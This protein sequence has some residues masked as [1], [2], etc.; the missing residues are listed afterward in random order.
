MWAMVGGIF[1]AFRSSTAAR[2]FST[3]DSGR[4]LTV[5]AQAIDVEGAAFSGFGQVR[6]LSS[7]DLRLSTPKVVNGVIA[8]TDTAAKESSSFAASTTA[9]GTN[10]RSDGDQLLSA[11]RIYPVTAVNFTIQT[12]GNVTF[13]APAG[14]N[15]MV[16]S[17][18]VAAPMRGETRRRSS[19]AKTPNVRSANAATR[20]TPPN[21]SPLS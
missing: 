17:A 1:S 10:I 14:S 9:A 11:Q 15:S 21:S 13:A 20:T 19:R 4:T 5:N 7:G 12:P 6:L 16:E 3:A 18:I 8:L 2:T